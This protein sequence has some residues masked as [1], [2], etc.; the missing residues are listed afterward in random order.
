M[1]IKKLK[2]EIESFFEEK[3]PRIKIHIVN[4][5]DDFCNLTNIPKE[6]LAPFIVGFLNAKGEIIIFDKK[7]FPKRNHDESEFELVLKHELIHLMINLIKQKYNWLILTSV[8]GVKS[9]IHCIE[10]KI[11]IN[12]IKNL[13][14]KLHTAS[15]QL[16]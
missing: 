8:N 11:H 15:V 9:L 12:T 7:L 1:D 13:F 2:K 16:L 6:K 5:I 14:E 10:K 3:L 4:N